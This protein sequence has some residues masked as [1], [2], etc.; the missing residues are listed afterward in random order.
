MQESIEYSIITELVFRG[1]LGT[2][3]FSDFLRFCKIYY[4]GTPATPLLKE[5]IMVCFS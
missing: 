4:Y 5:R 3:K 2:S 1:M